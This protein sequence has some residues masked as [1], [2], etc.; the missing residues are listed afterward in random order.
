MMK[1]ALTGCEV[2]IELFVYSA[3]SHF[4]QCPVA[5]AVGD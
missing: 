1:V 3:E 2:L 4:N 5:W